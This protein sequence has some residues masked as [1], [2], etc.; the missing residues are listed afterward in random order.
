MAFENFGSIRDVA[1]PPP[2]QEAAQPARG[3]RR[4]LPTMRTAISQ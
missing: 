2:Q 4:V 3:E 1:E